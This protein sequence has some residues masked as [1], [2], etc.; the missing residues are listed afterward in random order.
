MGLVS[1]RISDVSGEELDELT[2]VNIVVKSHSKLDEAKQIDVSEAEAKS[3]KLVSG[4]VEL[5]FR[6]ANGPATTVFA[7]EAELNKVAPIETLQ[8]AD[9]T[10]GRRR[11]WTQ[12][13]DQ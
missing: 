5:E 9:G 6:P 7:T 10:R 11:G 12:S 3:I 4:L 1:K 13:K 8:R 2:Y